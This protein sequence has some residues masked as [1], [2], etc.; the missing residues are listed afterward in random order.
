MCCWQ[1]LLFSGQVEA[2]GPAYYRGSFQI[3]PSSPAPLPYILQQA[4]TK[5]QSHNT[6]E[7][8][9]QQA[10]TKGQSHN[11]KEENTRTEVAGGRP[12][13]DK[14]SLICM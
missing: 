5:G 11:T 2:V 4:K 6:K 12:S 7:E 13:F 1:F 14:K 9:L 3:G 10:K 8:I